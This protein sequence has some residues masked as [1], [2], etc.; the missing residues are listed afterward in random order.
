MRNNTNGHGLAGGAAAACGMVLLMVLT[1]GAVLAD[2]FAGEGGGFESALVILCAVLCLAVA[3]G[4][5]AALVQRWKEV[6]RGEE[7]EARK[8]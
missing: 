2:H 4:V 6:R 8:Y 5:I 1:A 3:G 7:D